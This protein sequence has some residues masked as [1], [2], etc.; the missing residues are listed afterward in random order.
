MTLLNRLAVWRAGGRSVVLQSKKENTLTGID[1]LPIGGGDDIG[2]DL[3]GSQL[4]LSVRTDQMRDALELSALDHAEQK[5]LPV[6]GICRGSQMINIHRGG[7][8]HHDVYETFDGVPR[9]RNILAVRTIDLKPGTFLQNL[10][11][12]SKARI[13]VLHHQ[14]VDQLG[15]DMIINACDRYGI[16][17]GTELTADKGRFVLGVQWHPEF[18]VLSK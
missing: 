14:A 4:H 8:L 16:V 5:N 1:G 6:L 2:A 9:G 12:Q 17:Q 11:R 13:N 18:L 10:F 3:Y 7:N 15:Q